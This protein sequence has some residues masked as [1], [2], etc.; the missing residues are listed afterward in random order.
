MEASGPQESKRGLHAGGVGRSEAN[1]MSG[2]ALP[3]PLN[4]HLLEEKST[5][6]DGS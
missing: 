1:V 5:N 4:T 6:D 3:H 2:D